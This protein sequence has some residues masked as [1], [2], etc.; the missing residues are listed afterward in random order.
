MRVFSKYEFDQYSKER[1]KQ[2]TEDRLLDPQNGCAW[3]GDEYRSHGMRY[4][5]PIGSHQWIAPSNELRKARVLKRREKMNYE[6]I[7][8]DE[9]GEVLP[10]EQEPRFVVNDN[11]KLIEKPGRWIV[12]EFGG[13][14]FLVDNLITGEQC[15]YFD[16]G[17]VELMTMIEPNIPRKSFI[18]TINERAQNETR[19]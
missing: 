15:F 4:I 17:V 5:E 2:G 13:N 9:N 6:G 16:F 18:D 3:C 14:Q 8:Y 10:V 12:W 19:D 7:E 11:K 1:V